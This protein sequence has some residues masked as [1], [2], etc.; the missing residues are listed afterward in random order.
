[1]KKLEKRAVICVFFILILVVG[2]GI[3]IG[4]QVIYG[5]QWAT[6]P[7]N[8][9]I[10]HN[11]RLNTG[12]IIDRKGVVLLENKSDTGPEFSRRAS[13]ANANLHITG[14]G[15]GNIATGANNILRDKLVGYNFFTGVHSFGGKGRIVKLTVDAKANAIAN[16]ALNG[17]LGTVGVYNY[18]TGELLCMVSSPNY[19]PANPPVFSKNDTSGA[20]INRL[21]STLFVPG[22]IMKILTAHAALENLKNPFSWR[23]V[24]SGLTIINNNSQNKITCS[25]GHGSVSLKEAL[26]QSCNC[27]FGKL[28][29]QLGPEIMTKYVKKAGLTSSYDLDGISTARGKFD[30]YTNAYER[31]WSGVGQGKDL[32]N[33]F[34]MMV[35]M[36][37]I[38]NGG[39]CSLPFMVKQV[40]FYNGIPAGFEQE[41]ETVDLIDS[42]TAKI[43]R[44][45]MR[46]NVK[47]T[48]GAENF[49]GLK[50]YAKSGTA[51]VYKN[52]MPNGWFTGFLKDTKHPFAFIVLVEEGGDGK[53][54]AGRV[55]NTVLQYLTRQK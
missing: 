24:C 4:K 13:I 3:Y 39:E 20:Y 23:S 17:K 6:Y 55:A 53:N 49:P 50:I 46:N 7:A 26:A 42:D 43:L 45:Y 5:H 27:A 37:S 36:G 1:M 16:D 12:K 28:T 14:D 38:A 9:H 8:S 35:Y 30:F 11:R 18:K 31:A 41:G 15:S 22:S 51:Q 33:P 54:S 10:F 47:T 2:T 21:T 48:Y 32:I 29:N 34:S 44:S 25:R 19:N 40:S 52:K